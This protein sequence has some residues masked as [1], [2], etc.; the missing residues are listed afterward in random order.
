MQQQALVV[1]TNCRGTAKSNG[2]YALH[3]AL[4][5]LLCSLSSAGCSSSAAVYHVG[6]RDAGKT[7]LIHNGA[8]NFIRIALAPISKDP[9]CAMSLTFRSTTAGWLTCGKQ[10]WSTT[11]SGVHWQESIFE[12]SDPLEFELTNLDGAWAI[13]SEGIYR[14][15]D[16]GRTWRASVS[17]K[18]SQ[19]AF[20][21]L[22][23]LR[24]GS[25]GW[26]S[27]NKYVPCS[28]VE[29]GMSTRSEL[30]PDQAR[31]MEGRIYSSVDGGRSWQRESFPVT[32]GVGIDI[33]VVTEN[34]VWAIANNSV[35]LL[36]QAGWEKLDFSGGRA[37][38]DDRIVAPESLNASPILAPPNSMAF[39]GDFGWVAFDNGW[40]SKSTDGGQ[41]WR[42]CFNLKSFSGDGFIAFLKIYF[43]NQENGWGMTSEGTLY[44]TDDGGASWKLVKGLSAS[45]LFAL[46]ADHVWIVNSEGVF[47]VRG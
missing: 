41:T 40:V 13:T 42:D 37:E 9:N 15:E 21:S 20:T 44:S 23:F 3:L 39:V 43:L 16:D 34:R 33:Q 27:V 6:P 22:A 36:S 12:G 30:A 7:S 19:E 28:N 25:R 31:C 17:A 24:D 8:G 47:R 45:D 1:H 11:D 14:S 46:D 10:I 35:Y 32:H 18:P 2:Y 38:H 5:V 4:F 29:R 26:Y